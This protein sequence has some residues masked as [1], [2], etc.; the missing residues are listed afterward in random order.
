MPVP[1]SNGMMLPARVYVLQE[2]TLMHSVLQDTECLVFACFAHVPSASWFG[3][4]MKGWMD[5]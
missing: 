1:G 2:S 4:R 5:P 3:G